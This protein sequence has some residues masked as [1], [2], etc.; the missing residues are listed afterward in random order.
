MAERSATSQLKFKIGSDTGEAKNAVSGLTGEV[1]KL[2]QVIKSGIQ[3]PDLK[4]IE[5]QA[6]AGLRPMD[7][8]KRAL[9]ETIG[10]AKLA[11]K[12]QWSPVNDEAIAKAVIRLKE[13]RAEQ[14]VVIKDSET[15][16]TKLG[17]VGEK[18][19]KAFLPLVGIAAGITAVLGSATNQFADFEKTLN[20]I[21]AVSDVTDEE[22]KQ[23]RQSSTDLGQKTIF[24]NKQVADSYL[25]L[26]KAGFTA[27]ESLQAVPGLLNLAAAAG[28]DLSTAT[29]AVAEGMRA[30]GIET[31]RT[32]EF[33]D[34]LA[35]A[36]NKSSADIS[37]LAEAFKQIAPVAKQAKQPFEDVSALLAILADNGIKGADAGSDL[38]NIITRLIEP[39]KEARNVLKQLNVALTDQQGQIKPLSQLFEE[40]GVSLSKYD[41]KSRLAAASVL[42][43]AENLKTFS[44]L[45][46]QSPATINAMVAAMNEAD[47]AADRMAGTINQGL[48]ASIEQ[49]SGAIDTL[50]TQFGEALAP[51]ISGVA[52][53]LTGLATAFANNSW[54]VR[55]TAGA[56]AATAVVVTFG[57]ALSGLLAALAPLSFAIVAFGGSIPL[58]VAALAG[59]VGAV[60]LATIALNEHN[61][62]LDQA[63][64]TLDDLG[65]ASN[66][67]TQAELQATKQYQA[68]AEKIDSLRKNTSL[69]KNEKGLLESEIQK[70]RSTFSAYG[71]DLDDLVKKYGNFADAIKEARIQQAAMKREASLQEELKKVQEFRKQANRV[72]GG[73]PFAP[74]GTKE[75]LIKA[76]E[77]RDSFAK[78]EEQIKNDLKKTYQDTRREYSIQDAA[79]KQRAR[80]IQNG[81][82][83]LNL[84]SRSGD[85]NKAKNAHEQLS[86]EIQK[87]EEKL[88][89]FTK[90][91]IEKRKTAAL[92]DYNEQIKKIK[93]TAKV[94]KE[95]NSPRVI[96]ALSDARKV[97]NET[98][99]QIGKEEKRATE[100]ATIQINELQAQINQIKSQQ[101]IGNPFD[102]LVANADAAQRELQKTYVTGVQALQDLVQRDPGQLEF[103]RQRKAQLQLAFEEETKLNKQKFE[104]DK[105]DL[106]IQ[107]G[108]LK[109]INLQSKAELSGDEIK[110]EEAT[111][112]R[113][114]ANLQARI[115]KQ[116]DILKKAF[117]TLSKNP[118]DAA[119]QY[120]VDQASAELENARLD[121][122]KQEQDSAK[123]TAEIQVNAIRSVIESIKQEIDLLGMRP[124]LA[125][126]LLDK[127]AELTKELEKQR[128]VTGQSADL[129][130]Q[131]DR[132]IQKLTAESAQ[133]SSYT[134]SVSK[135]LNV[136]SQVNFGSNPLSSVFSQLISGLSELRKSFLQFDALM[137][138]MGKEGGLAN[139]V[140]GNK[141]QVA[142]LAAQTI[143]GLG[144]AIFSGKKG[145]GATI[146]KTITGAI[147]GLAAGASLGPIGAAAGAVIGATTSAIQSGFFTT[148]AGVKTAFGVGGVLGFFALAAKKN[149]DKIRKAQENLERTQRFMGNLTQNLDSND[150]TA[151]TTALNSA[152]RFKSGGGEAFQIKK[153]TVQQLQKAI[154]DRKKT[155]DEA[156]KDLSLQNTNL[157]LALTKFDD[158]PLANLSTDRTIQLNQ[159]TAERAKALEAFKDSLEAQNLIETNFQLQRQALYKQSAQD[160]IDAVIEE[161]NNIRTLRAQTIQSEARVSGNQVNIIN[162]N[163]QAQLVALDNEIAAFKGAEETKTEFLK[164]KAAERTAIIKDANDQVQDLFKQG[165]DII[166]EGLV[167]GETKADSQK[168]RLQNLFGNLNPLGL[169]QQDGNLVQT[170]VT[171]GS[172]AIQFT[173]NGVQDALGLINQLSNNPVLQGQLMS[174]LNI[175]A[176]RA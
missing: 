72:V 156:I 120:G 49:F 81:S 1:V 54:L 144:E 111:N 126:K 94:A 52:N 139:F 153:Q 134:D 27:S 99:K 79:D 142:G 9:A 32:G 16:G 17:G 166:N 84:G 42:A 118:G 34:V 110:I 112:K 98:L 14:Q 26:S 89:G 76:T 6:K 82:K 141:Q 109:N 36:A 167:I 97:Y 147:S 96:K 108:D 160:I 13:L 130:K 41:D 175:A 22:F 129:R 43:G 62:S 90:G 11:N 91:E 33:A 30:F 15:L 171:V 2:R 92:N 12:V 70:L 77:Q 131:N 73:L 23:I 172:G 151:L 20:T 128:N 163:L 63:R 29:S 21:R 148:G 57:A 161:Q 88:T 65:T 59:I 154:D 5:V 169:I 45:A 146:G 150:L 19:Q 51:I 173:V 8:L 58:V 105:A 35:Q 56:A 64:K 61:Q 85:L 78:R 106:I 67:A 71:I 170:N 102:D 95:V 25:E 80:S 174:I 115:D 87:V 10:Q 138:G 68:S 116:A 157:S 74:G 125:Q 38:R 122:S 137:K 18:L 66:K 117:D 100:N 40:I 107:L 83:T 44:T 145:L 114:L 47:G 69:T 4:L 176:A 31:S 162:A 86:R 127:N 136:F 60:G 159:L 7:D 103:A 46:G 135:F 24:N 104:R 165:L 143:Q 113:I 55:F 93:E 164:A 48:S 3:F 124:E 133:L 121:Y 53:A 101:T 37:D 28:G 168:K 50:K 39:S 75:E 149:A 119:L 155:I 123:K 140:K 152:L 132:E 158:Q